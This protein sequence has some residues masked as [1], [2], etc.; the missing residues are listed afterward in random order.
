[1]RIG[2]GQ[3][4]TKAN[5]RHTVRREILVVALST[6][7]IALYELILGGNPRLQHLDDFSFFPDKFLVLSLGMSSVGTSVI[8]TLST[9]LVSIL[10]M[11][12]QIPRRGLTWTAH[13][14]EVWCSAWKSADTVLTGGDD[15]L[16]KLWDLREDLQTAQIVCK[17][18]LLFINLSYGSHN[19]GVTS[20]LPVSDSLVLTGSYDNHL[21]L[22]D[23]RNF[24]RPVS[25]LDLDGGVWR[26][27]PRPGLNMTS[28]LTCCMQTGGKMISLNLKGKILAE[29][30]VFEPEE[31]R[32][33]IYGAS[34]QDDTVA[35]LCSFYEKSLYICRIP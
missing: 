12:Q 21:R 11:A 22:F 24:R 32:R 15:S 8:S 5:C 29:E 4:L 30:G 23:Y 31:E 3:N 17:R 33:L 34:W 7:C 25:S 16:L 2:S 20:I 1:M 28:F 14:L 10:D 6:G 9:G 27:L 13:D 35:A 26:I 18:S 19:A